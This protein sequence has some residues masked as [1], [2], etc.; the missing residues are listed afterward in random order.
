[1]VLEMGSRYWT[2]GSHHAARD[3]GHLAREPRATLLDTIAW[4]Q[5]MRSGR[6]QGDTSHA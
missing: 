5:Q 3:L 6:A 2:I 4:L 1:V